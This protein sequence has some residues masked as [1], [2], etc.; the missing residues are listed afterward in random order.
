MDLRDGV[1]SVIQH[2]DDVRVS[3]TVTLHYLVADATGAAATIEFLEGRPVVH[4]GAA[5]TVPV[6][7][8]DTYASS[9]S[10]MRSRGQG[11]DQ[12]AGA[13]NSGSL[14]R[15]ARAADMLEPRRQGSAPLVPAAFEILAEVAQGPATQWSIVYDMPRR[16]VH[17]RTSAHQPVRTLALSRFDLACGGPV[18]MLPDV[19]GALSGDVTGHFV[20]WTHEANLKLITGAYGK[21]SF[22]KDSPRQEIESVAA[23]PLNSACAPSKPAEK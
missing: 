4:T 19:N 22:L 18:M 11:G 20:S 9:L 10:W 2:L 15:F 3:G 14:S 16:E 1:A 13:R 17:F 12:G 8:N 6:L 5:L 21:V 23:Q 7:A